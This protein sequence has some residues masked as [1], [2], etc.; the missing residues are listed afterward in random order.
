MAQ[1][2]DA[3]KISMIKT[4]LGISDTSQDTLL[5]VYLNIA[6]KEILSWHFSPDTTETEVPIEYEMT[7]VNAVVI[8][9]NLQ[10][11]ENED[12]HDENGIHRRFSHSNM[13]DYI[14]ANVTAYVK[15]G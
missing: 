2:S 12:K 8:G 9:F 14:R 15:V 13:I 10:G 11:A 4:L 3:E 7:Q 6:K 1:M 5:L